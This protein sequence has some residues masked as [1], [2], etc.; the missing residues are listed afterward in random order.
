MTKITESTIEKFAIE[1]L[2]KQGYQYPRPFHSPGPVCVRR[3]GRQRHTGKDRAMKN[4]LP[5]KQSNFLLYTGNDGKVNVEVFLKDETVWLTQKAI[6]ELFGIER[7]VITKHL[8][9][10]FSSGKLYKESNAQ[11]MHFGYEER[12]NNFHFGN[13][14]KRRRI[15]DRFNCSEIPNS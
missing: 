2:E 3:T 12:A 9:N 10:I 14:S 15:A 11:K 13:S 8:K 7:S 5:D 1:L 6:G 4:N